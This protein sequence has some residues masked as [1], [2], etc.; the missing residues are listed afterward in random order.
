VSRAAWQT[1]AAKTRAPRRPKLVIGPA[2]PCAVCGH[3]R[4]SHSLLV[5]SGACHTCDCTCFEPRC[6]CGHLLSTHSWGT[7]PNPFACA[8]CRC[9]G[10]G[11]QQDE[12]LAMEL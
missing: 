2:T 9:L 4:S 7:P 3:F 12:Q 5:L 6:G 11:A 10:F 8:G 1:E